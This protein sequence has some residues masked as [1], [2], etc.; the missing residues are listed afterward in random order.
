MAGAKEVSER[1]NAMVERLHV[2]ERYDGLMKYIY[3]NPMKALFVSV[4]VLTCMFPVLIFL[5]FI[6]ASI[7]FGLISLLIIEGKKIL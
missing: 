1:F 6:F 5:G 4:S 3:E 2:K 7:V